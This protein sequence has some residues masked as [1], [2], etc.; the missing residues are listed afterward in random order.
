MLCEIDA[1]GN[2]ATTYLVLVGL[3]FASQIVLSGATFYKYYV[4]PTFEQWQY[5]SNPQYP[6]P[7]KVQLEIV[8]MVKGLFTA[9]I[10]PALSLYLTRNGLTY[11][12][13][14]TPFGWTY[15]LIMFVSIW[16]GCDFF[17]F[18]YHRLGH[19]YA[20]FWEEHKH[21]HVFNNPSPFAVIADDFVDQFCRAT[22]LV[23][24][25]LFVPTNVDLLF[26]EFTL[27]FY[28]Y[29]TYLHWGYEWPGLSAHQPYINS[30]YQHYLH[31][32]K[33]IKGKPFHTGF[34]FKAWD[35]LFGSVY[36]GECTC[37]ECDRKKGNRTR[38]HFDKIVKPDY[39][40]LVSPSSWA[41]FLQTKTAA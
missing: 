26:F 27:F 8:Q 1:T 7:E 24:I 30:A 16:I 4:N 22:P 29:G 5:K 6:S 13:C 32:A 36:T 15:E 20:M 37:A 17:E 18:Y 3:G 31:H 23:L 40:S 2:I 34:F 35:Q 21:H 28:G 14:G 25:P 19:K 41:K 12:Y 33:S 38:A 11:G 9:V 39:S 10:C